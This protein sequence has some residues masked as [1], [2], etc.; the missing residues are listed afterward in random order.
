[1]IKHSIVLITILFGFTNQSVAKTG[2]TEQPMHISSNSQSLDITNNIATF[3]DSVVIT[4]GSINIIADK[5]VVTTP[6]G[7]QTKAV[8]DAYGSPLKF[9]QLQDDGKPIEGHANQMRYELEIEKITLTGNAFI[10]QLD[11][12]VKGDKIV[13][14]VKEQK[15]EAKGDRVITILNPKQIQE[16]DKP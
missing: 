16:N 6:N 8:V 4:Q 5:V 9:S 12:N 10:S 7:D 14:L 11:S 3:T 2:D 13:Y 15:M 1:M